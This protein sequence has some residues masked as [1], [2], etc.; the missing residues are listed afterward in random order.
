MSERQH[1][2][3]EIVSRPGNDI[4]ELS[5]MTSTATVSEQKT[6]NQDRVSSIQSVLHAEENGQMQADFERPDVTSMNDGGCRWNETSVGELPGVESMTSGDE[7]ANESVAGDVDV[8]RDDVTVVQHAD[9][10]TI[11]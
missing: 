9:D 4:V 7:C 2:V 10:E 3:L 5:T 8:G 11:E 6:D 1:Y